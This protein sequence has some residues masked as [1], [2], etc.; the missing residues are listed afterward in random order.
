ME[1][2]SMS[3][4]GTLFDHLIGRWTFARQ[5]SGQGSMSGTASFS[6]ITPS[7]AEYR[8]S[9]ALKLNTGPTL[10]AEQQYLYERT[11]TGFTIHFIP[12]G[13]LFLDLSFEPEAEGW[14]AAA[15]HDCEPD[16]YHSEYRF[17]GDRTL[18]IRHIVTGPRKDYIIQT[19]YRR[20]ENQR[21]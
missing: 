12:S 17:E 1:P 5:I 2:L 8:E 10:Q 18:N 15:H 3:A 21:R 20:D 16:I 7:R 13:K 11:A 14:H 4:P 6:L 19:T 9:G